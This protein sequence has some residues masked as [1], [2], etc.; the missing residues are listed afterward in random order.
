[1]IVYANGCSFGLPVG[2]D[3]VCY[4]QLIA[5]KLNAQLVNSHRP[6]SGNRR[7][8][9]SSLR[10]LIELKKKSNEKI[11]A[12]VGLSFFFRTE[13]WQPD[14]P[15]TPNDGHFHPIR[16]ET[17][18]RTTKNQY[19]TS[20]IEQECKTIDPMTRDWFKQW[21]I[22]QNKESIITDQ[23]ADIVMF[24]SFCCEQKIDYLIWN[25]ADIWPGLPEVDINDVFIRDF[26]SVA[27]NKINLIDPWKFAFLPWALDQGLEPVDKDLYGEYGHPGPEAHRRLS[28]FLL[29]K[30]KEIR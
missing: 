6:G 8:I 4:S 1:M 24:T 25:N 26:V 2:P 27:L 11:L 5:E 15:A 29:E 20:N 14:L 28:A 9:R 12:L 23:L 17:V 3:S 10:D 22:W 30:I 13:L 18:V 19:Y 7:I 21:M 16:T